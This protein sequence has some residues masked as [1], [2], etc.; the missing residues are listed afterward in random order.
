MREDRTKQKVEYTLLLLVLLLMIVVLMM[1]MMTK[2]KT[3]QT[4]MHEFNLLFRSYPECFS[5]T[6][7]FLGYPVSVSKC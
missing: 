7:V 5:L 1:T 6:Q 3:L 2:C 4:R